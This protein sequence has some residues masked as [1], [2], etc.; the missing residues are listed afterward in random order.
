MPDAPSVVSDNLDGVRDVTETELGVV[1][2][3]EQAL[4]VTKGAICYDNYRPVR[5]SGL[6]R[7]RHGFLSFH[8]PF[9]C[10]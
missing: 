1:E 3:L 7:S 4:S 10:A 5:S 6:W 9:P 2:V 8:V